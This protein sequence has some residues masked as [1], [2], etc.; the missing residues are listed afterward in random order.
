MAT[1]QTN[2][3]A[4]EGAQATE[5][6]FDPLVNPSVELNAFTVIQD[7]TG[8][9]QIPEI[10]GLQK[11]A[12]DG[13]SCATTT[14]GSVTFSDKALEP[15]PV[16]HNMAF[17]AENFIPSYLAGDFPANSNDFQGTQILEAIE[18]RAQSGVVNDLYDI[19]FWGNAD[20][21]TDTELYLRDTDV[22]GL[23]LSWNAGGNMLQS[24]DFG[25]GAGAGQFVTGGFTTGTAATDDLQTDEALDILNNLIDNASL[26]LVSREQGK[27][28]HVTYSIYRNL[29]KSL[30]G[31]ATG[32]TALQVDPTV[33]IDGVSLMS[34]MGIPIIPHYRWDEVL[35]AN[36]AIGFRHFAVLTTNEN[37]FIGIDGT[38]TSLVTWYS[39]DDD[40]VKM[41]AKYRLDV[42]IAHTELY[43]A[44]KGA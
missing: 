8:K 2:S 21:T 40:N 7:V 10:A 25:T 30:S 19:L 13:A 12:R 24:S 42:E 35:L 26:K 34:Y 4:Y 29:K 27:A 11:T 44:Y 15:K 9:T 3:I 14:V 38:N 20:A 39:Q 18:S 28:F 41:R 17:C 23:Y 43:V 36:T 33:Q 5:I 16:V 37:N 22:S 31:Y 32:M 6:L 1:S